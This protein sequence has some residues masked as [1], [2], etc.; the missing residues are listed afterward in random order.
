MLCRFEENHPVH[1]AHTWDE[2]PKNA[3]HVPVSSFHMNSSSWRMLSTNPV[4]EQ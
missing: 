3:S 1:V 4:A 2:S